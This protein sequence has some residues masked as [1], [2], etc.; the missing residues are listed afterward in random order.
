MSTSHD[1]PWHDWSDEL[2]ERARREG[3]P[4]LLH[5]GA[6]WCH[7]CHVMD[8]GSYTHP[9]VARLIR[10]HFLAVRVDT[11]AR[12]DLNERYNQGGWPTFAVLD[13][14]GE[15]L[16]GRTYVPAGE[17][18][19]LLLGLASSDGRWSISPERPPERDR[20]PVE[21]EAVHLAVTRAFDR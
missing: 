1:F 7:W 17:L 5:I 8:E 11:D 15:V 3:R 10:E 13:A 16:M 20:A 6:T 21:V 9:G 4:V 18:H 19:L 12:P 14:D 2:F